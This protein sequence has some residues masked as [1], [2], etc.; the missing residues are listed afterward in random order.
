[1]EHSVSAHAWYP[2][3][4]AK[5]P[6]ELVRD[7]LGHIARGADGALFFQWRA[8]LRGAEQFLQGMVSH[9][10]PDSKIGRE[11]RELGAVLGRLAEVR[12]STVEPAR[13]A[14]LFDNEA[15]W[16]FSRGLKPHKELDYGD[17]PRTWHRALWTRNVLVDVVSPWADL[18]TYDLVVVPT[19]FLVDDESAARSPQWPNAVVW[20]W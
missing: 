8:S 18:S 14:L 5:A 1:M 3:N 6:R 4:R 16:A 20:S 9:A 17:E 19:L 7:S 11:V 10:G 15:A 2:V 13:V 12:G